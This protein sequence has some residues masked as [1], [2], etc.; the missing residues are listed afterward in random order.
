MD[1]KEKIPSKF[2]SWILA[3]RPKT[4][5]AAIVPVAVGSAV[6]FEQTKFEIIYSIV[7]LICATLIQVGTNFV[8]DYFDFQTGADNE[9]RKGPKRGLALGI[10]SLKEMKIGSILVFSIAFLFGL[11]LVYEGGIVIL[12]IGIISILAG[13][14]YTAGPFPFAYNGLGDI[15]VF[16]FFGIV[17][18]MGTTYLQTKDFSL[19]S[20]LASIPV[21]ALITNILV[22][23]NFRDVEEDKEAKKHTLAVL[24]GRNFSRYQFIVLLTASFIIP[25][26]FYFIFDFSIWIFLPY[27]TLPVAFKLIKMLYT[28]EGLQLNQTLELTA[29]FSAIFGILFAIGLAI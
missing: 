9:N 1:E 18:T 23:N 15:I 10:I 16:I 27:I 3:S 6:A 12:I 24:L 2:Q 21:G 19:L 7:A 20:F 8:N 29:K 13:I 11:Y 5:L 25:V 26:I 14:A 22:V 28:F 4:L 17:G